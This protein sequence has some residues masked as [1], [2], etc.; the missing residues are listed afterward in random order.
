MPSCLVLILASSGFN[1]F[2]SKKKLKYK[3]S[4][5]GAK[6]IQKLLLDQPPIHQ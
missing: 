5:T 4:A 2:L 1:I 6:R 3:I